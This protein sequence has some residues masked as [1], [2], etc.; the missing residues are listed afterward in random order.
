MVGDAVTAFLIRYFELARSHFVDGDYALA[1]FFA[2]TLIEECGKILY[3]RDADVRLR[4]HRKEATDHTRKYLAAVVNLLTE[5]DRFQPLPEELQEEAFRLSDTR[6][7]MR[8]RNDALYLRFDRRGGL[9]T[10][11]QAFQRDRAARYVYLAGFAAG[12]LGEYVSI[13]REWADSVREKTEQFR[14]D[15]L[16]V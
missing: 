7:T 12:E 10:P 15:H 1:S 4:E 8:I 5:S 16:G 3:L 14:A 11:S 13:D 6:H 9:T 2:L